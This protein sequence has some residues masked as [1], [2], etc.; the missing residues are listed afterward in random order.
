MDEKQEKTLSHNG[1][2]YKKVACSHCEAC[3]F[4]D[5]Y[6]DYEP[7]CDRPILK[8]FEGCKTGFVFR[9]VKS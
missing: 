9:E 3:C 2:Q 1:K 7:N 4:F 8:D 5:E 6:A